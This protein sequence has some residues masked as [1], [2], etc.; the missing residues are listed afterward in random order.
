MD[1]F[2]GHTGSWTGTNG[3]RL[4]PDDPLQD[5]P[6]GAVVRGAAG[7]HL[8][9]IAYTWSHPQDGEQDG[10]LVLGAGEAPGTV[11][12]LWG[13]SWHQKPEPRVLSGTSAGRVLT[14]SCTYAGDWGWQVVV[15]ASDPEVLHLSMHN[16]IPASAATD[17]M[18]AGPYPAMW[19]P[20]R[21]GA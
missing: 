2:A 16:V 21:R 11:V 5:A 4:M 10:L 19:A 3:F 13:D 1:A 8:T 20:L 6:A 18:R 14:V 7:G 12:G 15:D 17:T 9:E